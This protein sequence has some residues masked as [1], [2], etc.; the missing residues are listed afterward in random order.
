MAAAFLSIACAATAAPLNPSYTLDEFEF[1]L[2][3]LNAKA[4]V[5]MENSKSLAIQ[6]AIQK[7]IVILYLSINSSL[8]NGSFN[9]IP[10]DN[11]LLKNKNKKL[12][13]A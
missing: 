10:S 11:I 2:S 13:M 4:L 5:V 1:Y 3:D 9:L 8:M 12:G 7:N 6:A